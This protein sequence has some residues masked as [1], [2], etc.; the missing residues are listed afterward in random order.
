MKLKPSPEIKWLYEHIKR[1]ARIHAG[2]MLSITIASA[3]TLVDPLIIKW[4]IDRVLPGKNVELLVLGITGFGLVYVLR[5]AL[6]YAGSI[7][8]FM[9]AQKMAF[10]MRMEL[11]RGVHRRTA[12]F[13]ENVAGGEILHCIDQDVSRLAD[14]AGEMLP[15]SARMLMVSMM[16]MTAMCILSL[17]LTALLSPLLPICFALQRK[18][19][20]RLIVAADASQMQM[21][22]ATRIL[23][24]HLTGIVQLQLLNR[25]GRHA[26]KY[27]REVALTANA[28]MRQRTAEVR[29]S[30]AYLSVIVVGSTLILGYGGVEVIRDHLTIGS[31]VAFYSYIAR[32]F[33]PLSIAVDLQSKT[34]RITASIRHILQVE[35]AG[36]NWP[37]HLQPQLTSKTVLEFRDVSFRHRN[38][39]TTLDRLNLRAEA[40]EKIALVGLSG[41]GKSTVA[42][43]AVGLYHPDA[44]SILLNGNEIQVLARRRI[45]SMIC[46][47][48]QDPLLFDGTLRENL[49][50]GDPH[51]T[52]RELNQALSVAQLE[53]L[54]RALP[55]GLDEPLGP[56]GGKLSGGEKK[57]VAV[58]RALLRRPRI[59]ILDE[60]TNGLDGITSKRL[61]H[62]LED[63]QSGTTLI[64]ISHASDAIAIADRI[65]VL[66]NGRI[67]DQGSHVELIARCTL[68]QQLQGRHDEPRLLDTHRVTSGNMSSRST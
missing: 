10:R 8:N 21:V 11:L 46:L 15:S 24:E 18:Y 25:H 5:M 49:L 60:V 54:V 53:A 32:L 56:M 44:G 43:L 58:A 14:L 65:F 36:T 6:T 68:F 3:L 38:G 40:G 1:Y 12:R 4:L 48:P 45:R 16:V 20:A 57:R 37:G 47:V 51:A 62:G 41:S 29:F 30:A 39:A 26:V 22:R 23:Q 28:Q 9:A 42:H 66:S 7:L 63:S 17:R 35:N 67:V 31:L 2:S 55:R 27:A 50:C 33:E 34:Q 13:Y 59:L 61:L 19:R 64:F 52:M